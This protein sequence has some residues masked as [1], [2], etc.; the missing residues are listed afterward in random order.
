MPRPGHVGG[1]KRAHRM[2][3]GIGQPAPRVED[4]RLLRGAGSFLDDAPPEDG[5]VAALFLRSPMAHAVLRSIDAEA[6]RGMPG[7]A[8][9]ILGSDLDGAGVND[10]SAVAL[11]CADGKPMPRPRRPLIASRRVR[12]VGEPVALVLADTLHQARDAAEAVEV[13]YD[14]LPA[15][16]HTAHAGDG[17]DLHPEA[18]GNVAFDWEA[19]DAEATDAE[20]ARCAHRVEVELVNNRVAAVPLEPRGAIARW[21]AEN[22]TLHLAVGSQGVWRVRDEICLRL[23]L[24]AERVW[25]TTGDVGGGFGAKTM[26]YPE[27]TA[28]AY[29]ARSLGRGV[30]WVADRSESFLSDAQGRDHAVRAVA[31]FDGG[32]RLRALK[33]DSLVALGAYLSQHGAVI[34]S[35]LLANVLPGA[36]DFGCMHYRAR[37]VYTSTTP[38]DAYRGAG[39]PEANYIV[40]RVMDLAAR[41]LGVDKFEIRRRS[42]VRAFPYRNAAGATYD[43]GDYQRLLARAEREAEGF[44]NRRAESESKGCL[45]GLGLACYVESILGSPEERAALV[46]LE[47]GGWELRVGTQSTGQGHATSYLQLLLQRTGIPPERVQVAQGDSRAIPFGGGTGGSRSLTVQGAAIEE[48]SQRLVERLM[49]EAEDALEVDRLDIEHESG[50]YRAAG[51]D[52]TVTGLELEERIRGRGDIDSLRVDATALLERRSFP[53]GCH[54]CEVEIDRATGAA[55]IDR[56]LAVD[57]FGTLVNPMLVEGQVFGGVAQ[58]LGQAMMEH[59]CFDGDGQPMAGSFMD[60]AMPRA[61]DMPIM[62]FASEPTPTDANPL[63]VKGCGEAGTVGALPAVVN[64]VA[65]A[66]WEA[67]V[68][69]VQP[70]MTPCR[71]WS[72]LQRR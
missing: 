22:Q 18:P 1:S 60:Y 52:R 14:E 12:Y 69:D 38:V 8:A 57:D 63:G 25:V 6:A 4:P 27:Y 36:Y 55:R 7:V 64:A 15:A 9:V 65:D 41:E 58:G 47:D 13:D 30:R 16:P 10:T 53:S 31:G 11:T 17:L 54:L 21:D 24:D 40:E 66:L 3:F 72:L 49:E 45:R 29:A 71:I 19:G 35:K 70:P 33:V 56:Y 68:R 50:V 23:G 46:P 26:P 28:V 43:S 37:G 67:G 44:A 34:P 59:A 32:L 48:A 62:R 5:E 51:S 2:K 39:R 61:A 20:L 42:L